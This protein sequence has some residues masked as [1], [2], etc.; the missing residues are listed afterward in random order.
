MR[1]EFYWFLGQGLAILLNV[2]KIPFAEYLLIIYSVFLALQYYFTFHHW[3]ANETSRFFIV[4]GRIIMSLIPVA[5]LFAYMQY[6]GS[7]I[8][9]LIYAIL[10]IIYWVIRMFRGTFVKEKIQDMWLYFLFCLPGFVYLI[11]S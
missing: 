2:F 11:V 8:I 4:S 1:K 10:F 6:K 3:F 9:F 7:E 5:I